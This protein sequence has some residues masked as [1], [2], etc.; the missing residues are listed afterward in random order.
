MRGVRSR[1]TACLALHAPEICSRRAIER[2]TA[3]CVLRLSADVA[4][5][6]ARAEGFYYGEGDRGRSSKVIHHFLCRSLVA[7]VRSFEI[8]NRRE[9][10]SLASGTAHAV[11][12]SKVE[13]RRSGVEAVAP[14]CRFSV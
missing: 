10:R 12:F 2:S 4:I 8:S 7:I 14:Q 3:T 9:R 13:P 11:D 1:A 6:S 5:A